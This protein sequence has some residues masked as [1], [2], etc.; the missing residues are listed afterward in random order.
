M[1]RLTPD[2]WQKV[3]NLWERDPRESFAW[4]P[5]ECGFEISRIAVAKTARREGWVKVS[6]LSEMKESFAGTFAKPKKKARDLNV[7]QKLFAAE[8][9]VDM[10]GKRAAKVSGYTDPGTIGRL[11]N[12][13]EV[14]DEVAQK[15]SERAENLGM[16]GEDVVRHWAEVATFDAN[17]LMEHRRIPCPYCYAKPGLKQYTKRSYWAER[18]DHEKERARR[19]RIDDEDDIGPFPEPNALEWVDPNE[20]PNPECK[21]CHGEGDP[22]VFIKDTRH[23]SPLARRMYC[24]IKEGKDG[25]ELIMLSKENAIVNLAKALGVFKDKEA[26]QTGEAA[27]TERLQGIFDRIMSEA[28]ERQAAVDRE[29]GFSEEAEDIEETVPPEEA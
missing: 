1:A 9:A 20:P 11:K 2:E 27:N 24:G 17:E 21:V 6:K 5:E 10:N 18:K 7:R 28:K 26:E 8:Y 12:M 16:R 29:R 19:L 4:V 13:P 3:R 22:E 14:Q 15:V 23:L 25:I